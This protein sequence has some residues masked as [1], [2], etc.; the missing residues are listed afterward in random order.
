MSGHATHEHGRAAIRAAL[1]RPDLAPAPAPP[2]VDRIWAYIEANFA[3]PIG[4]GDIA[5]GA[6]LGVRQLQITCKAHFGLSPLQLLREVRLQLAHHL[7]AHR[8]RAPSTGAITQ[9]AESVGYTDLTR[10]GL[11]YRR[12]FGEPPSQTLRALVPSPARTAPRRVAM[13][14]YRTAAGLLAAPVPPPNG[15]QS[16]APEREWDRLDTEFTQVRADAELGALFELPAG[17]ELLR[18]RFVSHTGGEAQQIA[19]S[20]LPWSLVSGTPVA[21]PACEPRPGGTLAQLTHLGHPPTRVQETV[22]SRMPTLL[23][24]QTLRLPG[25]VPVLAVTRRM[26]SHG[27]A[28][29]V[30]DRVLPADRVVLDYSIDL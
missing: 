19:V 9:V 20:F 26:I 24:A 13:D 16:P 6:G 28:V 27:A 8:K 7:L 14:R 17:T 23:E 15:C 1:R 4:V 11:H 22:R 10:F 5:A 3:A 12:R 21:D 2:T 18:R 29:E 25:G 30:C